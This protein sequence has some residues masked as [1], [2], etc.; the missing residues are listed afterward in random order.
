MAPRSRFEQDTSSLGAYFRE[1]SHIDPLSKLEEMALARQGDEE[2]L[3]ELVKHNLKYVVKVAG[4]YKG[5][6]L[7]F[8]D[9][10]NEGN[11]GMIMAAKRYKADRGVKFITYAV[12]WIRQS[13]IKIGRASG[14]ERV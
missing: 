1:I 13:I 14:R 3:Q 4:R 5:M 11:I 10:I 9:L 7:S 12:W 6:G 8:S 2:A